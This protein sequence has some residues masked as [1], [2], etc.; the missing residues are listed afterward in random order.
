MDDG[1]WGLE[2]IMR[3]D[4][5]DSHRIKMNINRATNEII[6]PVDDTIFHVM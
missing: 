3:L 5:S 6:A 4:D 2:I 1:K